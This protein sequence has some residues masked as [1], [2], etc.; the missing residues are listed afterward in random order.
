MSGPLTHSPYVGRPHVVGRHL[1][2]HPDYRLCS[3]AV[4][5]T[6]S[7]AQVRRAMDQVGGDQFLD[8]AGGR[9]GQFGERLAQGVVALTDP[10]QSLPYHSPVPPRDEVVPAVLDV[11]VPG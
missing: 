1:A 7:G 2:E 11:D 4:V 10:R 5:G 3:L 8:G 6:G 9:A